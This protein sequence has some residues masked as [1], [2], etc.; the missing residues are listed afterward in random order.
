MNINDMM[1]IVDGVVDKVCYV[2]EDSELEY[3]P[4]LRNFYLW[5]Y[6]CAFAEDKPDFEEEDGINLEKAFEYFSQENSLRIMNSIPEIVRDTIE[7]AID[8]K[9]KYVIDSHRDAKN[10]SLTD[11]AL[12]EF[13][14]YLRSTLGN[15][16]DIIEAVGKENIKKFISRYTNS[17]DIKPTELVEAMIENKVI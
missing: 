6:C 4:E 1:T 12:S 9:I 8:K 16:N 10:V 11:V 7:N 5:M 15:S 2:N 13:I 3:R 17:K 14:N